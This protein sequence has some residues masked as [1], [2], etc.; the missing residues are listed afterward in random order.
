MDAADG[1]GR[2]SSTILSKPLSRLHRRQWQSACRLSDV[3]VRVSV[4]GLGGGLWRSTPSLSPMLL[5]VGISL[6][7]V[8]MPCVTLEPNVSSNDCTR[9]SNIARRDQRKIIE[10]TDDECADPRFLLSRRQATA[11]HL[12]GGWERL[13]SSMS[14][15]LSFPL[16]N[17]PLRFHSIHLTPRRGIEKCAAARVSRVGLYR[18]CLQLPHSP[19]PDI[20]PSMLRP[21]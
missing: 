20:C 16:P 4:D 10:E 18:L 17:L 7:H 3:N 8:R 1:T 15:P 21:T 5:N 2:V 9:Y 6:Y 19:C 11:H 13:R 12:G 14:R